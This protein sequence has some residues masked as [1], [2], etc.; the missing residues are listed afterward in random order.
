M[1]AENPKAAFDFRLNDYLEFSL[2]D[3]IFIDHLE[4]EGQRFYY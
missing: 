3:N 1:Q 4:I 2:S